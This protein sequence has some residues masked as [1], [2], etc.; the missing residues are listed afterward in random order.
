MESWG[1]DQ[2]RDRNRCWHAKLHKSLDLRIEFHLLPIVMSIPTPI[3]TPT[4]KV[5]RS[6]PLCRQAGTTYSGRGRLLAQKVGR[7]EEKSPRRF[8]EVLPGR[9]PISGPVDL[10]VDGSVTAMN[11]RAGNVGEGSQEV[12]HDSAVK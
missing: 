8:Q 2:N 10:L 11:H 5:L 9:I 1:W 6:A 4:P 3:P 12:G 7:L